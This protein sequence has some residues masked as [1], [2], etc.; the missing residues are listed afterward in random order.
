MHATILLC[1]CGEVQHVMCVPFKKYR[2]KGVMYHFTT[3]E[4]RCSLK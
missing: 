3:Y 4:M 1:R 2:Q